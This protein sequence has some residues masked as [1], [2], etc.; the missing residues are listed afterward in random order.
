MRRAGITLF[1]ERHAGVHTFR[2][3]FATNMLKAETSLQDISQILGHSDI[4]VTETYLRVVLS[5]CACVHWIW[6]C[7]HETILH[8]QAIFRQM[9]ELFLT[10]RNQDGY[11]PNHYGYYLQELDALSKSMQN[12]S[13]VTKELI[14]AWDSAKPYL[15]KPHKDPT[16]QLYSKFLRP[17]H[18]PMMVCRMSQMQANWKATPL[19]FLHIFTADEISRI[20]VA[21]DSLPYR[22]NAPTMASGYSCCH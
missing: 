21:A 20:F 22:K 6:R 14:E 8:F 19:L 3:S 17:L 13:F 12:E 10:T 7:C 11:L 4:N 1:S 15:C 2:H 5:N 9:M 18:M 16:T